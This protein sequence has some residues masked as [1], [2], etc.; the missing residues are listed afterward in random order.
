MKT[1]KVMEIASLLNVNVE[2]VRRW[3]RSGKLRSSQTSKKTGNV[4][5]EQDLFEFIE[6]IPKYRRRFET[7]KT[8]KMRIDDTLSIRLNDILTEMI[9]E[10]DRLNE[11]IEELQ[12]LLKGLS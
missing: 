6:T 3:I 1:Y 12:T 4:V 11:R 5:D 7:P 8:P 2:T 10:R 9:N